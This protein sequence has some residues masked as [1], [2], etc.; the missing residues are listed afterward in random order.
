MVS[1]WWIQHAENTMQS[2]YVFQ[3][4]IFR[5]GITHAIKYRICNSNS[6][7]LH[8][9]LYHLFVWALQNVFLSTIDIY[10]KC[11]AFSGLT[12]T[13]VLYGLRRILT[14]FIFDQLNFSRYFLFTT[15]SGR[16]FWLNLSTKYSAD[17]FVKLC[18]SVLHATRFTDPRSLMPESSFPIRYVE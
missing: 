6:I 2:K 14:E 17:G 13:D 16:K 11:L 10:L 12:I 5:I 3:T 18:T 4:C 1:S 7:G 8:W 9:S 15:K